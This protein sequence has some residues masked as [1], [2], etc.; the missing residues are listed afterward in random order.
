M[1][2]VLVFHPCFSAADKSNRDRAETAATLPAL[3][4]SRHSPALA[5]A[6][7]RTA[8]IGFSDD[9]VSVAELLVSE[10]ATNAVLHAESLLVLQIE[11]AGPRLK[12]SVEDCSHRQPAPRH[13]VT[14]DESTDGRGLLLVDALADSWG[15]ERTESGKLVWFELA[16]TLS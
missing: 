12:V 16:S 11:V 5:R 7:V 8:L 14:V 1:G 3:P 15:W 2:A 9:V 4:R 10:L 13:S 6:T